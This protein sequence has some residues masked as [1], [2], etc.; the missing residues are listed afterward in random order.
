[1]KCWNYGKNGHVKKDCK[2]PEATKENP[3]T[4]ASEENI[5]KVHTPFEDGEV[6]STNLRS[7]LLHVWILDSGASFHMTPH[8]D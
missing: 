3:S 1:M 6:L 2:L 7:S 8:K 4:P 5:V